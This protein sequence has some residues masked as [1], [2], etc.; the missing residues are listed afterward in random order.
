L[1]DADEKHFHVNTSIAI[2]LGLKILLSQTQG[3]ETF[4]IGWGRR[5][6]IG[7]GLKLE[8][9]SEDENGIATFLPIYSQGN[10]PLI[11][12]LT[13]PTH[14]IFQ[15]LQ[16]P[17]NAPPDFVLSFENVRQAIIAGFGY[18]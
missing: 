2:W 18:M 8:E 11:G 9:Q 17:A 7:Y 5:K 15:P 1:E 16:L 6:V 14:L 12:Q 4:W 10:V 13:I 3:G